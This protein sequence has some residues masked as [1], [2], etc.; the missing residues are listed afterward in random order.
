MTELYL[1]WYF[2]DPASLLAS[3]NTFLTT[4]TAAPVS[5]SATSTG[6]G[7]GR[8]KAAN[9]GRIEPFVANDL[10]KLAFWMATGSGK[11]LLM[12]C[13]IRQYLHYL[14]QSGQSQM[15][16]RIILLTPNEGL[17]RQHES[18]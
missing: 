14:A 8:Q 6:R 11:T 16:N 4:N 12:H 5:A 15:L 9:D 3:L 18:T 7:K 2:R 17:S 1:D 13:H 10:N